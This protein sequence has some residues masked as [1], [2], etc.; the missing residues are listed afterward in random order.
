[1]KSSLVEKF[2]NKIKESKNKQI[3]LL[4]L[5]LITITLITFI[6]TLLVPI[7]YIVGAIIQESNK[8]YYKVTKINATDTITVIDSENQIS[9]VKLIGIKAKNNSN[10][11]IQKCY[12]R[13][14]KKQLEDILLNSWVYLAKDSSLPDKDE[15]GN[16]LRY[17][18]YPVDQDIN[19]WD[20][21]NLNK[22]FSISDKIFINEYLIYDGF[23]LESSYPNVTYDYQKEFKEAQ[24]KASK[25][26]TSI[27]DQCDSQE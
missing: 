14:L 15:N 25:E 16:L 23:A 5:I 26:Q 10:E 3:I 1:M 4:G 20:K 12:E 27:W 11:E 9:E 7:W 17:V 21:F 13:L 8:P 18:Y 6:T 19:Y 2:F 22:I 24:E